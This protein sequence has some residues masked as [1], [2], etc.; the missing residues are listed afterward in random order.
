MAIVISHPPGSS[1]F[2]CVCGEHLLM[3]IKTAHD[4]KLV[5]VVGFRRDRN[6]KY[7]SCPRCQQ[8][9]SVPIPNRPNPAPTSSFEPT[10]HGR[11]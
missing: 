6:G 9:H 2:R 5:A 4:S 10:R 7:G 1:H 3:N 8:A 11:R